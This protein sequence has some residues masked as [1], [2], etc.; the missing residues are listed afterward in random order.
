MT[1]AQ[2][3]VSRRARRRPLAALL[4]ERGIFATQDEAQRW[5]MA[6]QVLVDGR[7][8]DKP[9]T[10]VP[11]DAALRVRGRHRY[12]SRGGYKLEAV[13]DHFAVPV[14]G[15]VALD[16]GAAA[17]GFTD[18]LLQRGAAL[19]YAVD[20]GYG[21][22]AGRLRLDPR[23]RNLERTNLGAI[24]PGTLDPPPTLVTL[25]LSYLS[26]TAAVPQAAPLLVPEGDI[27]AL[28][29]PLFEVEDP[30]AG[31]TGRVSD[32]A[33]IVAA[34]RRV[35]EAGALAGLTSLGAAKLALQPRHGV[36][37]LFVYFTNDASR[38][39]W[40]YDDAVLA[41]IVE[42]TGIGSEIAEEEASRWASENP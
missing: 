35:L 28:F 3:P 7:R 21:Q 13:L 22:L 37:E 36:T 9:G 40:K 27:L 15:R 29:K 16:C 10:P 5:I 14:A 8:V 12:V 26:L 32:P 42:N 33:L 1:E 18:C 11:R 31:R 19:V 34:L 20:V 24:A 23:V 17:G 6:G 41:E 4:V 2:P 25:D 30:A 39:R 38:P